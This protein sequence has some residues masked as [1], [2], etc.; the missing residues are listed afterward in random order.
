M[1]EE[2]QEGPQLSIQD[3][4][5]I[6]QRR[7][8]WLLAV[9]FGCWALAWV[10]SWITPAI[11]RSETLIL[12][13]QQKVPQ[14]Y[15]VSN[16]SVDLQERLQSMTQQIL[17]RTRLQRIIDQF[18]LYEGL[19]KRLGPDGPVDAMRK[20]I[21]I[22]LVD[23]P[24]K[25]EDLTAFRIAYNAPNPK[26]AQ[27]VA[28]QLTSL[29]ID[30][31]LQQQTQQAESTTEFLSNELDV[32]R[33]ALTEQ[34]A[35]IQDF[36]TRYLGELPSQMQGNVQIL[37]GL[38]D[39]YHNVSQNLNHAQEQKLY[40]ESL[41]SQYRSVKF[42]DH[43]G[44]NTLPAIQDELAKLR[45]RLT[46]AQA[47]YTP[48]HPDVIRLK[49]Q[50]AQTEKMKKTLETDLANSSTKSDRAPHSPSELQAMSP[51]LQLES[52]IKANDQEVSDSQNELTQL[53]S[54]IKA[55]QSRLNITPVREQQLA[56]LTRDYNQSK[57]NYDSLLQKQQQSQLATNLEKSQQGQQFRIIDPPSLAQRPFSP[58]R[59]RY[60]ALGLAAGIVLGFI[61]IAGVEYI[62]DRV[63]LFRDVNLFHARVLV[64]IPHLTTER[65]E[66]QQARRRILEWCT[67]TIMLILMVAGN[68]VTFYKA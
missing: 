14:Q 31:N 39:R 24:G 9:I 54:Q 21:A 67:A 41:L 66:K 45:A 50:I 64:G 56:D 61:C 27:Q 43:T 4:W 26:L 47:K 28:T 13:E 30:E 8:W 53:E 62:D 33:S 18:H 32:A 29:F 51:V 48:Q 63:R 15:V 57:S 20:D 17:S 22:E 25:S 19:K 35:K 6:L 65:Q 7:R 23:A 16:V 10:A 68:L 34:E 5:Q 59:V 60:S 12:V 2:E 38:Q 36:Q 46:D 42:G 1:F 58:N 3:Y 49:A 55:Y 40:L 52:Q 11:Y 37:N 44:T